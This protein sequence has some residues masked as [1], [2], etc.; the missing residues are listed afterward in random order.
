MTAVEISAIIVALGGG[1]VLTKMAERIFAPK[2]KTALDHEEKL[3]NAQFERIANMMAATSA[4]ATAL[5]EEIKKDRDNHRADAENLR[6][7]SSILRDESNRLRDENARANA[8]IERLGVQLADAER[9][10]ALLTEDLGR[11]RNQAQTLLLENADLKK[12]ADELA[13][14]WKEGNEA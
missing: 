5:R 11:A 4:E 14:R 6:R 12:Q 3:Q 8:T 13:A 10:M 7:E 9:R 1:G 2:D